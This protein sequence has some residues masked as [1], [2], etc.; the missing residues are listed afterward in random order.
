MW[1]LGLPASYMGRVAR[2]TGSTMY[3]VHGIRRDTLRA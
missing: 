2:K 3:E 1:D